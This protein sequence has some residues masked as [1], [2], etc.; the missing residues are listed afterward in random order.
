MPLIPKPQFPNVPNAPGVPQLARIPT[1]GPTPGSIAFLGSA[2]GVLFTAIFAKPTWAIY[3][4]LPANTVDASGITTMTVQGDRKPVVVPDSFGEFSYK[5]GFEVSD[6]PVQSGG[7]AS[8]NKVATPFEATIRMYK[9]GTQT[10]RTDFL[11]SIN[12]ILSTL[13]T[14]D[15]ITPDQSYLNV[16]VFNFELARR[17][18]K[19]AQFLTE[20]D[21]YFREIRDVTATYSN[22]AVVTVN[23]KNP[24]ATPPVNGG[25]VQAVAPPRGAL[26]PP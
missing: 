3:K 17:G 24:D 4:S 23:A 14:Y 25:A 19:G 7:F 12:A 9:G 15:I 8:Y 10:D 5:Q 1:L 20:V 22:T 6:F 21:L 13:D 26:P 11:N 2:L 18:P 16:N